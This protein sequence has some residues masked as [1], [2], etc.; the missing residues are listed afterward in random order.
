MLFV[1]RKA[2]N[3][4]TVISQRQLYEYKPFASNTQLASMYVC[5]IESYFC[6][7]NAL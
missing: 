2:G 3:L 1:R 4:Y 7:I 5:P 6:L